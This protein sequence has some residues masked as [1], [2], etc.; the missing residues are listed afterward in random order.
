MIVFGMWNHLHFGY[1]L[2]SLFIIFSVDKLPK[3]NDSLR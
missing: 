2:M 1:V 3:L